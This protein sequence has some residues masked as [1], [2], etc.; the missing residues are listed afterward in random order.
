[1]EICDNLDLHPIIARKTFLFISTIRLL[2]SRIAPDDRDVNERRT[3]RRE[4][5]FEGRQDFGSAFD[6]NAVSPKGF[7]HLVIP[8]RAKFAANRDTELFLVPGEDDPPGLVIGKQDDK[9]DVLA[10]GAFKF[11]D[12][13]AD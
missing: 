1:M 3:V 11:G 9:G 5:L 13:K 4:A 10:G 12:R 2:V 8:D 6:P 7:G